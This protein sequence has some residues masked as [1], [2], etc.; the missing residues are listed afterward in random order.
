MEERRFWPRVRRFLD[1]QWIDPAGAKATTRVSDLSFGGCYLITAVTPR[2]RSRY[3]FFLFLPN[4]GVTA[5]DAEVVHVDP[6]VGCGVR[7]VEPSQQAADA[8]ART[9]S[10]F[11]AEH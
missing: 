6:D 1:A 4:E 8:L 11:L 10:A 9:V 5:M 3:Q 2:P 7:F